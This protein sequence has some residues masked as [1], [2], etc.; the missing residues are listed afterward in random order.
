MDYKVKHW[1]EIH[2]VGK[3]CIQRYLDSR[4][5]LSPLD[6]KGVVNAGISALKG[7]YVLSRPSFKSH[8]IFFTVSGKGYV[9][10]PE[11]KK[12]LIRGSI[13]IVPAGQPA[14]YAI[15]GESWDIIWFD[16]AT[17][18]RWGFLNEKGVIVKHSK[19]INRL[20]IAVE[21][22][23][24]EIHSA[25]LHSE[26]LANLI[27]D[28]V[29][30]YL[31][32]E[33]QEDIST[34][35][36]NK[37]KLYRLYKNVASHLQ[38]PWNVEKLAAE[39]AVSPSYLYSL[40]KEHLGVN[41]MKH[42]TQLRMHRAKTLL[43]QSNTRISEIATIVGYDNPYNFSAAFKRELGLSPRQYRNRP[44]DFLSDERT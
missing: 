27:S 13:L 37:D 20:H 33:L 22:F 25:D 14:K 31:D 43:E 12:E 1:E 39:I 24:K 26:E 23:Y 9:E 17:T 21:N 10:T 19:D 41:P 18:E 4:E 6:N 38:H 44:V 8:V 35:N 28:E 36:H 2:I 30:I 40:C 34:G 7:G 42:V 15:S 32:R 5:T 3:S 16:L 11:F 29:I